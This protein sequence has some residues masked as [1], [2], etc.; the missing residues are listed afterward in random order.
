MNYL[1]QLAY[2][3]LLVAATLV[4]AKLA[5]DTPKPRARWRIKL[6]A[7]GA[8]GGALTCSFGYIVYR[9]LCPHSFFDEFGGEAWYIVLIAVAIGVIAT[10]VWVEFYQV[11]K[12][13]V[14]E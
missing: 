13:G 12:K 7:R 14:P 1:P 3:A 6:L 5:F 9:L 11:L 10:C 8:A 4:V 2:F